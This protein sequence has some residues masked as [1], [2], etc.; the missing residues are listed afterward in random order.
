MSVTHLACDILNHHISKKVKLFIKIEQILNNEKSYSSDE[1]LNLI[2][3]LLEYE[4][5]LRL[6]R[7]NLF[8]TTFSKIM[9]S[10]IYR[11]EDLVEDK[12]KFML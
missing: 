11:S 3:E 12:F 6:I 1:V 5:E 2:D 9:F 8:E 7:Q 4:K 10:L